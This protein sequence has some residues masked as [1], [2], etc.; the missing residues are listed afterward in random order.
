MSTPSFLNAIWEPLRIFNNIYHHYFLTTSQY[1]HIY[2]DSGEDLGLG[3]SRNVREMSLPRTTY[4][5]STY[6]ALDNDPFSSCSHHNRPFSNLYIF[7]SSRASIECEAS[8]TTWIC[9]TRS[10]QNESTPQEMMIGY[11]QF[12]II[13]NLLLLSCHR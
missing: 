2:F 10:H 8:T 1:H 13:T 9:S 12:T 6:T 11:H 5:V 3:R 4:P 7:C